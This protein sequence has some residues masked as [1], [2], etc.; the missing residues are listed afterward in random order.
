LR[1]ALFAAVGVKKG[2]R[3][4]R[5]GRG[6]RREGEREIFLGI[7][8]LGIYIRGIFKEEMGPKQQSGGA[9]LR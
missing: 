4:R 9:V 6:G 1:N 7:R 8:F 2:G 5:K 3:K